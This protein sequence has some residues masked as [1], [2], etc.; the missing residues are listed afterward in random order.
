MV[1]EI[2]NGIYSFEVVLPENPLK[3]L[4]CYVIKG[5]NGGRDLLV[6][7]GFRRQECIDSLLCGMEELELEFKNTDVLFTHLHTDHTGNAD[8]LQSLGCRLM[9]GEIDYK[10]LLKGNIPGSWEARS[11]DLAFQTKSCQI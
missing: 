2:I 10:Q 7:C 4:N 6:D 5:S 9:M 8:I 3:W 11:K 1:K